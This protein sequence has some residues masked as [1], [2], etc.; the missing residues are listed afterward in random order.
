MIFLTLV[1][2]VY[3]SVMNSSSVYIV[4]RESYPFCFVIVKKYYLDC[5]AGCVCA[6]LSFHLEG[7]CLLYGEVHYSSLLAAMTRKSFLCYAFYT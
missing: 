4:D 1:S 2:D 3:Q 7:R 5:D 6:V